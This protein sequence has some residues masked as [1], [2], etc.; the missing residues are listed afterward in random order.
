MADLKPPYIP[1]ATLHPLS[2]KYHVLLHPIED[3]AGGGG[4]SGGGGGPRFARYFFALQKRLSLRLTCD[5]LLVLAKGFK[6]VEN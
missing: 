6:E 3:V 1:Q 4:S 2:S 5:F